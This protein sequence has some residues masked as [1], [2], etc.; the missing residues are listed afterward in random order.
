MDEKTTPKDAVSFDEFADSSATGIVAIFNI[1][2]RKG[3][4]SRGELLAE[5][6]R[7]RNSLPGK[8]CPFCA[9][10]VQRE[11][12]ACPHCGRDFPIFRTDPDPYIVR[13]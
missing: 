7:L 8:R 2:E 5:L 13:G 4:I 3:L 11:A 6:G 12:A 9:G 10:I 1:L